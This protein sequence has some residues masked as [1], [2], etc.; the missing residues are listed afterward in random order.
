MKNILKKG[1]YLLLVLILLVVNFS[2]PTKEVVEAKTLRDL[3]SELAELQRQQANVENEKK[4]T[5]QEIENK[6]KNIGNINVEIANINQQMKDLTKE[7]EELNVEIEEKEKEIKNIMNYYQLSSSES[8]YLE[9]IFE[10]ADFTD[11]IYRMAIAEQLS[12]Y[13][14]KLVDEYNAKIK[15]N[16]QKKIDLSNKTVELNEKQKKLEEELKSLG[17]QLGE[18]MDEHV[19]VED[20][21]KSTKELINFYENDLNCGM[22]ED[23]DECLY[24]ILMENIEIEISGSGFY[25][26]VT[27][28]K[29]SANYGIYYPWGYAMQHYGM[30]ISQTGHGAPVYSTAYGIVAYITYRASCGGNMVYIHHH[31]NGKDYTSGY[32]HLSTINVSVGD[33]VTPNTVIGTVGGNSK[34]EWWD[35]CSTGTHLHFQLART[36]IPS[37]PGFYTKFNAKHFN[38]RDVINFPKEGAY[39][40]NRVSTY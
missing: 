25:R 19:T 24:R 30:D 31:V 34:Y 11:F 14:D 20:D 9:Y 17:N 22:D 15:E 29:V 5:E 39:F 28:G 26:P 33:V 8:A 21:I 1:R 2:I 3:K 40:Y 36:N 7:I 32:F 12:D 38:P 23:V 10:A 4:L 16:E 13:N 27:E 35:T 6:K 37:G 18:I